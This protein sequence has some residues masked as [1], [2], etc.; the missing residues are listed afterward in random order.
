MKKMTLLFLLFIPC[1]LF[2]QTKHF[3]LKGTVT[4]FLHK[5]VA[6]ATI[7]G[8]GTS[9]GTNANENGYYTFRTTLPITLKVSFIGY[10]TVLKKIVAEA[11]KDTL[12]VNFVLAID[13]SQLQPVQITATQEPELIKESGSLMDFDMTDGNILVLSRYSHGDQI[14]I[15]DTGMHKLATIPLKHHIEKL[16][17]N[18]RLDIYFPEGDSICFLDYDPH[19]N[20]FRPTSLS[21]DYYNSFEP[22]KAYNPPYYYYEHPLE[23]NSGVYYSAYN[24][25]NKEQ[26]I[27][28]SY[29]DNAILRE[30]T[31]SYNEIMDLKEQLSMLGFIGKGF[32]MRTQYI[33]FINGIASTFLNIQS[34]IN[35]V[36]DSVY[37]FNFN[38]DTFNVYD[39]HNRLNRV[40][41]MLFDPKEAKINKREII[42][43]DGKRE[44]YLTYQVRGVT[45]LKK[46]D[47]TTGAALKLQTIKFPF[48]EK[49]RI[50][51][52]YAYYTCSDADNG[53]FIRHLYRQKIN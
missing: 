21:Q 7:Q 46:I 33:G 37:V 38:S 39:R 32:L 17:R 27:I 51:E 36:N 47:L 34:Q 19:S 11:G 12:Q 40:L 20:L 52:G 6:Y 26:S 48:I 13:S 50:S 35:V 25:Q 30:N 31:D 2:A 43:D 44:C 53:M 22:I 3:V 1:S 28:Y 45:Y 16:K 41:P 9:N 18:E 24:P 23:M 8:V 14:A 5:P 42:T 49:L 29:F 10:K 4:D 15:Y